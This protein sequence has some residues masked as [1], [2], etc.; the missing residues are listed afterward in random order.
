MPNVTEFLSERNDSTWQNNVRDLLK[1]HECKF[2]FQKSNG[3]LREMVCTLQPA[4]IPQ[5]DN[6][7]KNDKNL[8][9]FDVEVSGW[10][11]IPFDRIISFK[12]LAN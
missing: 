7:R 10:R 2:L 1:K 12:V 3:E 8:T 5:V 6:P 11:T 9:V 4:V